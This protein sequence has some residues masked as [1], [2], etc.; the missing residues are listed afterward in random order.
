[1]PLKIYEYKKCST[2]RKATK[3]L[4]SRSISYTQIPIRETPPNMAE[5]KIMLQLYDGDIKK[6]FNRSGGDYREM[7]LKDKLDEMTTHQ[8]L[9][10]MQQNGNLVKRPFAI[11]GSKGI[12]GF[13]EDEWNSLF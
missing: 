7:N 5:L 2:C 10:L 9:K 8:A 12:V 13:K 11:S 1:M 4:D 3:Y 6:L